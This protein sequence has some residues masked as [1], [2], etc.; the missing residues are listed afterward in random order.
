MEDP[1]SRIP[2]GLA[3]LMSAVLPGT[4]QLAEGRK[5]AFAY[6]GIEAFAWISHFAWVDAGN[7]KEGEY[8]AYARRHWDLDDWRALA[9][10]RISGR[11][12]RGVRTA[13]I[14]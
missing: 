1:A 10:E 13:I 6:L 12:G 7:K 5:R 8:E 14:R 3:F 2:P 11:T 4:G 9:Y